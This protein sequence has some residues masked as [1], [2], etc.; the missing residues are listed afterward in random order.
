ME[1]GKRSK[2]EI[3]IFE[4]VV[5]AIIDKTSFEMVQKRKKS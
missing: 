3:Q 4:N 1:Y 5:P 2:G